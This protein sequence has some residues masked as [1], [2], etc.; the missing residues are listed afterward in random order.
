M[1]RNAIR[2]GTV[3]FALALAAA[4]AF[5]TTRGLNQIVTPD[6][7][8]RGILLASSWSASSNKAPNIADRYEVQAEL[9]ITHRSSRPLPPRCPSLKGRR[10]RRPCSDGLSRPHHEVEARFVLLRQQQRPFDG[11]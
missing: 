4:P 5:A 3:A 9:G 10:T 7:Q 1:R 11:L 2:R 8:P 6:V